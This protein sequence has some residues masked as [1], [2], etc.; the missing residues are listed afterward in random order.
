MKTAAQLTRKE[1]EAYR[2]SFRKA[3]EQESLELHQRRERA[4]SLARQAG[5]ILKERYEVSRVVVF[6]SLAGKHM[7]TMWSDVDLAAW[8]LRPEDTFRAMGEIYYLDEEIV[9]NLVDV[10]TARPSIINT[11]E[12]DGIEI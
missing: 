3:R 8:G 11:I 4:W 10:N 6:G 1:I 5:E 9:V 7:F 2:R 12:K